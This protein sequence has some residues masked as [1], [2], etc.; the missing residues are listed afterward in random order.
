[1]VHLDGNLKVVD[2]APGTVFVG[3]LVQGSL[4]ISGSTP[5]A[6]DRPFPSFAAA[7]TVGL[8]DHDLNIHDDHSAVFT[9]YYS[10]QIKTGHVFLQGTGG[11]KQAGR[12][13]IAAA[14]SM[15]YKADEMTVGSFF[16]ICV[17]A[18][19][20]PEKAPLHFHGAD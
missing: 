13:T 3:F 7:T 18:R 16:S 14:K 4:N 17:H 10:E 15:C 12:V 6:A 8:T 2:S 19:R 9:D 5:P 11:S 1:M 20:P